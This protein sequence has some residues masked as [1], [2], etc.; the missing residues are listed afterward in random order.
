MT[1]RFR[2][3]FCFFLAADTGPQGTAFYEADDEE[4][5][6]VEGTDC[7]DVYFVEPA[8]GDDDF[9]GEEDEECEDVEGW[10]VGEYGV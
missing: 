9:K 4:D 1:F 6:C 3:L 2:E 7:G 8:G 10:L 5:G